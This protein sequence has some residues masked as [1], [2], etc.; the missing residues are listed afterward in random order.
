[1]NSRRAVLG[2]FL[3]IIGT[4][5]L[6][7]NIDV[8]N[9]RLPFDL[10]SWKTLVAGIGVAMIISGRPSGWLLVAVGVLFI[11]PEIFDDFRFRFR[12]WWPVFIIFLGIGFLLDRSGPRSGK[13]MDKDMIDELSILGGSKKIFNSQHF[14]GG[15]STS[16][17]GGS[18]LDFRD[19][20]LA[21]GDNVLD[22]VAIMGGSSFIIPEDWNIKIEVTSILG[23]FSDERRKLPEN[24]EGDTLII[25]GFVLMGG[26]ELKSA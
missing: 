26:G 25:K 9:I 14:R 3:I 18:E 1:M 4:I 2:L 6:L 10:F 8:I 17:L 20:K 15:K 23:G 5:I 7:D 11:L 24:K 19:A 12:D 16:I 22:M 21:P 13:N